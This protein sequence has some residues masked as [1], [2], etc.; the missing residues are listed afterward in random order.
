MSLAVLLA[1]ILQKAHADG[2]PCGRAVDGLYVRAFPRGVVNVD[3]RDRPLRTE[4][5]QAVRA[6]LAEAGYI[7]TDAWQATQGMTL[8][9]GGTTAG[10]S[11][12]VYRRR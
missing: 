7:E 12:R 2:K 8:L 4:D 3:G 6:A 10:V 9:S 11:F 5:V 1:E